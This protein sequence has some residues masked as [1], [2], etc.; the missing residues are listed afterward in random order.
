MANELSERIC[1]DGEWGKFI[2]ILISMTKENGILLRSQNFI[3]LQ[4]DL[5]GFIRRE[6]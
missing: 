6:P 3:Y 2:T 1:C 5:T 4:N